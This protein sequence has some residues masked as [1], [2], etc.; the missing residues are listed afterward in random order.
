M[1]LRPVLAFAAVGSLGAFVGCVVINKEHC[2]QTGT[3][4]VSGTVCS[5]CAIE[6]NGCVAPETIA[7]DCLFDGIV[8]T[9]T[10]VLT[11]TST[12]TTDPSGTT[13]V[14]STTSA[15]EPTSSGGPTTEST[16]L[17][18]TDTVDSTG[19]S[20]T[21]NPGACMGPVVD[22]EC[23]GDEPYCVDTA[24][25][26]CGAPNFNCPDVEPSKPT[27]D[28]NSGR[29]VECMT[30]DDCID[31]D[32]PFCDPG[33]ANCVPCTEHEQCP[34]TAC[35]LE[36]GAC[37][38]EGET[39][40]MYVRNDLSDPE[41]SCSDVKAGYGFVPAK[42]I[43][44][45]STAMK[46]VPVGKPTTIKLKPGSNPQNQPSGLPVG[47]Y[48]VAIVPDG[49]Q[50]PSLVMAGTFP[51]VTLSSGNLVFMRRIG[52]YNN[53]SVTDPAI[54]CTDAHLWLDRQRINNTKR[55]ILADNCQVH[56]RRTL[57][58]GNTIGGLEIG[59]SDP[60]KAVVWLENSF[61]TD[62][63]GSA[64]GALRLSGSAS[65][66]LL[67]TTV[68]QNKSPVPPIDCVA[69]WNGTIEIRNSAI[70]DPGE[71]FA[72]ACKG[73]KPVTSHESKDDKDTL[74]TLFVGTGEG[75]YQALPGGALEGKAVW[76][77]G[78]PVA[79]YNDTKRPVVEGP[80]YAGGDRP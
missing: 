41:T 42:P 64:F 69:G 50:V 48:V 51:A 37:F 56:L 74:A 45:L 33:T 59:G 70:V 47:N 9:S 27:C 78:D 31:P 30:S 43:C 36:T 22:G 20:S 77:K 13:M 61:L 24:C 35:N 58:F 16:T 26:G 34:A 65:A 67:Y 75:F 62:N 60:V 73:P 38:P 25:V 39:D 12:D 57:I 4:C 21:T 17:S 19:S 10:S 15:V 6:N 11:T 29:C 40:I 55:A 46:R 32:E 5:V 49:N 68:V 63:N 23:S 14:S 44:N 79:D 28:L 2:A 52:I 1:K 71:H 18:G 7:K 8:G 54:Q 3:S 53:T 72:V 80:D 66:K 76:K